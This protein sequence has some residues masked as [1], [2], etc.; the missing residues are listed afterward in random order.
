MPATHRQLELL[1]ELPVDSNGFGGGFIH[2]SQ[3]EISVPGCLFAVGVRVRFI[4]DEKYSRQK[5]TVVGAAFH[6]GHPPRGCLEVRL[7]DEPLI[8]LTRPTDVEKL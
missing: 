8:V 3:M 7:D 4:K 5:G 6:S 2:D 1:N